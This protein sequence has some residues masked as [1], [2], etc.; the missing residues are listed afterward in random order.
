MMRREAC[1][2]C[3]AGLEMSELL[4]KTAKGYPLHQCCRCGLV[5][6][7]ELLDEEELDG[8]YDEEYAEHYCKPA[9]IQQN[10]H[11]AEQFFADRPRGDLL[12][13][14]CGTGSML[15]RLHELGFNVE[16]LELSK[17]MAAHVAELPLIRGSIERLELSTYYGCYDYVVMF[18]VL[19]HLYDPVATVAKVF[20]LLRQG[21]L[22][23][24]YMPYITKALRSRQ[25]H[26]SKWIHFNPADHREHINFFDE[27]TIIHLA[28]K[29]GFKVELLDSA[30]DDFWI[31]ARK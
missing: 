29:G 15:K 21:G 12:E 13:I 10:R 6:G 3:G 2:L 8:I 1:P 22:W 24:N 7:V 26:I 16:G 23:F 25:S 18:H 14:G 27:L 20:K 28:E 31:W 9:L 19:E 11:Y 17:A 30:A 5:F 4:L